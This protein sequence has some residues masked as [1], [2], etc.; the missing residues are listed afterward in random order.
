MMLSL[1]EC[2]AICSKLYTKQ[3][4]IDFSE[5][6][7]F[8]NLQRLLH[9]LRTVKLSASVSLKDEQVFAAFMFTFV[10]PFTQCIGVQFLRIN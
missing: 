8:V 9:G 2:N 6:M 7:R 10:W 4:S 1:I 3:E 5:Q